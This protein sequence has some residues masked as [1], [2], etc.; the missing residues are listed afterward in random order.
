M[1]EFRKDSSVGGPGS[2]EFTEYNYD[3]V[4]GDTFCPNILSYVPRT[5]VRKING[6]EVG[7]A[8]TKIE[9]ARISVQTA[10]QVGAAWNDPANLESTIELD[11]SHRVSK[12]IHPDLTQTHFTFVDM[13]TEVSI[14][15]STGAVGPNGA[16]TDGLTQFTRLN[17]HGNL[18]E[19]RA[20]DIASSVNISQVTGSNFDKFGRPQRH[21]MPG[22]LYTTT[23]Y[24]CCKP[25]NSSDVEGIQTAYAYDIYQRLTNSD[26]VGIG[27][28]L[29]YTPFD[30]IS[31]AIRTG[32][33]GSEITLSST[34]YDAIGRPISSTDQAG[35]TTTI[36]Y[37]AGPSV[38]TTLPD[39]STILVDMAP[40]GAVLS[41][42]GTAVHGMEFASGYEPGKGLF[43]ESKYV[44]GGAASRTYID[45]LGRAYLNEHDDATTTSYFNSLGQLSSIIDPDAIQAIFQYDNRGRREIT[46][47]DKNRNGAIDFAGHDRIWKSLTSVHQ[48]NGVGQITTTASEWR[49]NNI[50]AETQASAQ[51]VSVDGLGSSASAGTAATTSQTT[52]N[53]ATQTRVETTTNPDGTKNEATFVEGLATQS[54][55]LDASGAVVT[56]TSIEYDA[57]NRVAASIDARNGQT[58]FTY[59]SADRILT[60][61]TPPPAA[62]EARQT[63]TYAYD[64]RG[65]LATLTLP[66]GDTVTSTYHPTGE[67]HTHQGAQT[68]PVTYTYDY[69]GRLK[70]LKTKGAAG[71]AVTT[72]IYNDKGQLV[73]KRYADGKGPTYARTPAGRIISRTWA[74]GITTTY[75]RDNLGQLTGKTYGD[76]GVTA[77]IAVVHKRNGWLDNIEDAAGTTIF[78]QNHIGQ[79]T[80]ESRVGAFQQGNPLSGTTVSRTYDAAYRRTGLSLGRNGAPLQSAAYTYDPAGRFKTISGGGTENTYNY[81]ANSHLIASREVRS[82]GNLVFTESR[83]YDKLNRLRHIGTGT[84]NHGFDYTYDADNQRTRV[85]LA[86]GSHWEYTYDAKG[87]LIDGKKIDAT[88]QEIP[89]QSFNYSYDDIGNRTAATEGGKDPETY[90]PNLLNQYDERSVSARRPVTGIASASAFVAVNSQLTT[91]SGGDNNGGVY[92][93][94]D[95]TVDNSQDAVWQ[96]VE[97]VAAKPADTGAGQPADI[98]QKEQGAVFVAKTPEVRSHDDDGNLLVDGRWNYTWN[99]ENRLIKMATRVDL[100]SEVPRL[101]LEFS[102]DYMGR[103]YRK[104]VEDTGAGTTRET[105][106]IY[107]GWNMIREEQY[108]GPAGSNLSLHKSAETLWGVDITGSLQ[109]AGGVGGLLSRNVRPTAGPNEDVLYSYDA[110][111]NVSR[112]F[113]SDSTETAHYE[114][115]P[116]GAILGGST[117]PRPNITNR[118]PWRFST[119]YTDRETDLVYYGYRYY[120]SGLGRWLSRDPI[121]ETGGRNIY[122]FLGNT[123]NDSVDYLGRE[124]VAVGYIYE[125]VDQLSGDWYVGSTYQNSPDQRLNHKHD[126]FKNGFFKKLNVEIKVSVVWAELPEA[127]PG[128][129]KAKWREKARLYALLEMEQMMIDKHG[130]LGAPGCKNTD[131][132][133]SDKSRSK[134][135][136]LLKR[137]IEKTCNPKM[138]GEEIFKPARRRFDTGRKA[139]MQSRQSALKAAK[140]AGNIVSKQR[141]WLG[142]TAFMLFSGSANASE[143]FMEVAE[144]YTKNPSDQNAVL[145]TGVLS[146]YGLV[147][148]LTIP[149]TVVGLQES[150]EASIEQ[151]TKEKDEKGWFWDWFMGE[152]Y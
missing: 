53:R 16:I 67:L 73:E 122:G 143:E 89:G 10:S 12:I 106:F 125:A 144:M 141:F 84:A 93:R 103:R 65:R 46:A 100:P 56:S 128:A 77:P 35:N 23:D 150:S 9:D 45:M 24:G 27:V 117:I 32:T 107:D 54:R 55:E 70:T 147:D 5:V 148:G 95:L 97:T 131:P 2:E 99:A 37:L 49:D 61:Q 87:Q 91:R 129:D 86:D 43:S 68:Y 114:Y 145:V 110:N 133:L 25:D 115:T 48:Q 102:Y 4:D 71:D 31:S 72:W 13:I 132:A 14:T 127:P 109:G 82:G 135:F 136:K 74:R 59:D 124:R 118:N 57:H 111:G 137:E 119:R 120:D 8:Y 139:F 41:V 21:D 52:I 79:T 66:S 88:G 85:D 60:V 17:S 30:T 20:T 28:E 63:T 50:D 116:F 40:D 140:K 76:G 130:G 126:M 98:V 26:S 104:S 18:L 34:T 15:Q 92:F 151:L 3:P 38:K 105:W 69:A 94:R 58:D 112:L 29:F 75:T 19:S 6:N 22:G 149:S 138:D 64:N 11:G 1:T 90:T 44:G 83:A 7:R 81:H 80:V 62:G 146:K 78:T 33:D 96:P 142:L 108:T 101:L 36:E 47:L 152:P 123:P 42:T 113:N 121:E 134:E 51:S 39:G